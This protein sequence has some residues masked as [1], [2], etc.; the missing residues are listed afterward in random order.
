MDILLHNLET[1]E[2]FRFTV[3]NLINEIFD[4]IFVT[5]PSDAAKSVL[6]KSLEKNNTQQVICVLK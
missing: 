2:E 5:M 6:Q 4:E 3:L 1:L